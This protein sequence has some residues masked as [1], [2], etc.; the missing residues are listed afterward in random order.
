MKIYLTTTNW[1]L[2]KIIRR[3]TKFDASHT[4][5]GDVSRYLVLHANLI[6]L[7]FSHQTNFLKDNILK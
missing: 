4:G 1:P 2:S 7:H 3:V 5:I 6:G